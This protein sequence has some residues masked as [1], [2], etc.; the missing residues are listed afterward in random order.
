MNI[1]SNCRVIRS[2]GG[3]GNSIVFHGADTSAYEARSN[4][5]I[6]FGTNGNVPILGKGSPTYSVASNNNNVFI[7]DTTNGTPEPTLETG[8]SIWW[9]SDKNVVRNAKLS[10]TTVAD[11]VDL[12][13]AGSLLLGNESFRVHNNS[14]NHMRFSVPNNA[15]EYGFHIEPNANPDLHNFKLAKYFTSGTTIP[16]T[17][18]GTGGVVIGSPM[19]PLLD[20]AFNLGIN[21]V[22]WAAVYA[23][24]GT[25]QSSDERDKTDIEDSPLGLEFINALRP[26]SYKWINGGNTITETDA[27][28][29]I[30]GVA[31]RTGER[32][33]FG[34]LSQQVKSVLPENVD[35][36]GWI[37]TDKDDPESKQG[38]PVE[39]RVTRR[40]H[41]DCPG[42][43]RFR[44]HGGL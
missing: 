40:S 2:S 4:T 44:D 27:S 8:A 32:V 34:L 26:V 37:L 15:N 38:F 6:K 21:G 22:R 35:F 19:F 14:A 20:D 11:S 39:R 16:I 41:R 42:G 36:G 31:S 33:H 29:N 1:F 23:V 5:F 25:I 7:V 30:T 9:S 24:N 3:S 28:G 12:A 18:S 13:G 10:Q 43:F 17:I